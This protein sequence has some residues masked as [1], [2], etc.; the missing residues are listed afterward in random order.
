[1]I[2]PYRAPIQYLPWAPIPYGAAVWKFQFSSLI[3]TRK[4]NGDMG[5]ARQRA[6]DE[7]SITLNCYHNTL[8]NIKQTSVVSVKAF[9]KPR[10]T[11]RRFV[12]PAQSYLCLRLEKQSKNTHSYRDIVRI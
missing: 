12:Y 1:M 9:G 2:D 6:V 11:K 4:S 5:D 7:L 10:V 8:S 3:C